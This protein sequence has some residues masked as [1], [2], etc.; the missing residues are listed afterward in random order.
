MTAEEGLAN[1]ITAQL[2]RGANNIFLREGEPPRG[3]IGGEIVVADEPASTA[4]DLLVLGRLCGVDLTQESEVDA[5]CELSGVNFRMNFYLANGQ[6]TVAIRPIWTEVPGM[7]QLGLPREVL[8]DWLTNKSGLILVSGPT[9]SGKSTTAA[10]CLEHLNETTRQHILT[11]ED[12]VEYLF[13]NKNSYFSQ[14]EIG[15]DAADLQVALKASLRQ[16]PDVILAGEVSNQETAEF[17]LRAAETGHLVL[18]TLHAPGVVES[19]RRM[20]LMFPPDRREAWQHLLSTQLIGILSQRLLA[21]PDGSLQVVCEYMRNQGA[22]KKW[23]EMGNYAEV[24]DFLYRPEGGEHKAL[25]Q[26]L[27]DAAQE[28]KVTREVA[29]AAAPNGQDFD[30]LYLGIS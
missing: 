11:V 14:R 15:E 21:A 27:V 28:G 7:D 19:M 20:M 10:S 2:E 9:G 6:R 23:I 13:T 8:Q 24:Q 16:N 5:R 18:S 4:D 17:V 30:R 26:G 3:R 29:R 22:V 12:P 1:L 25:L